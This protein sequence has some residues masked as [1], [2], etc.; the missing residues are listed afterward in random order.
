VDFGFSL[1]E[2]Q[3]RVQVRAWLANV[4]QP[5]W[6]ASRWYTS[7]QLDDKIAIQ[8]QWDRLLFEAGWAGAGWPVDYG[9]RGASPVEQLIVAEEL[10]RADAP[11]ELNRLGKTLVGPTLIAHGTPRQ[12]ARYLPRILDGSEVWCQGFSEP[13]AGSDLAALRTLA[14]PDPAGGWRLTGQKVWTSLAAYSDRC[15]LLARTD[16]DLATR[17]HGLGLFLLDLRAPGVSVRPL[18]Q[19]NDDHEFCEIFLDNSP[20]AETDLVGAPGEGWSVALTTLAHER[21]TQYVGRYVRYWQE[22]H[23]LRELAGTRAKTDSRVRERL[24]SLAVQIEGFRLHVYYTIAGMQAGLAP[25]SETAFAKLGWSHLWQEMGELAMDLLG[26]VAWMRDADPHGHAAY[27]Q[28]QYLTSRSRTIA[29]GT[30]EV[31]RNIIA[32]RLLGLPRI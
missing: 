25:G 16:P 3:L 4:V 20:V 18:H 15:L 27:W 22:W 19:I 28:Y 32:E 14:T 12:K 13:N 23:R 1:A 2:H 31:Q 6:H 29:G 5:E 10:A 8:R 9:G 21:G 7:A 11:D 30:S 26:P 17:H 24:G